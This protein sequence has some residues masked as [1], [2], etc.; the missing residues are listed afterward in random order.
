MGFQDVMIVKAIPGHSQ[1]LADPVFT[2]ALP[3]L[4][5]K[6]TFVQNFTDFSLQKRYLAGGTGSNA[7]IVDVGVLQD[8][9]KD[10]GLE[11]CRGFVD[12]GFDDSDLC[13]RGVVS[14]RTVTKGNG[15]SS[16]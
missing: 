15:R 5:V 11:I 8:C 4:D 16:R 3:G 7:S 10:G 14:E 12:E 2:G 1:V 13:A 6:T 9:L